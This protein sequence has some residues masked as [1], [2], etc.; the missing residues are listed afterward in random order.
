V[1]SGARTSRVTTKIVLRY[2][3]PSSA[4]DNARLVKEAITAKNVALRCGGAECAI[5]ASMG[6]I[7]TCPSGDST[8]VLT[9]AMK[10]A[11]ITPWVIRLVHS[12]RPWYIPR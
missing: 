9:R 7:D 11:S 5:Q 1:P 6:T 2:F 3:V 12:C 8:A 10:R 4:A